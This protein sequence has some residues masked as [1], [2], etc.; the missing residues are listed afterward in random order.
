MDV[1]LYVRHQVDSSRNAV[2]QICGPTIII[3]CKYLPA[4]PVLTFALTLASS[5][6]YLV[7][8]GQRPPTVPLLLLLRPNLQA[9]GHKLRCTG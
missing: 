8:V 7:F 9:N 6:Y 4:V 3:L 5:S 1:F 2:V